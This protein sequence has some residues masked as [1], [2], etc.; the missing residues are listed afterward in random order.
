MSD[1]KTYLAKVAQGATLTQHETTDAFDLMMSGKTSPAQIGGFLMALRVRG[2]TVDEITGAAQTMRNKA[3]KVP[4]PENAIDTCGT[5]GD[6]KGTYNISTAAA[7]VVA[8]A[9]IPVAKHGNRSFTS[10]SGSADVLEALGVNLDVPPEKVSQCISEA[11]IGFMFAPSHHSAMR[12]VGPTRAE[13]GTRTLFNLL[14]PLSNPASTKYQVI[15]VFD[16]KWAEPLAHVLKNLGSKAVWVVHGADGMDE[17]TTTDISHITA[18]QENGNITS[19]DIT[20]EEVGLPRAQ[21]E[22]LLG[23]DAKVNASAIQ[24]LLE[25]TPGP[26]QDIVCLNAAA[27]LC[28]VKNSKDL[29]NGIQIAQDSIKSGRALQCLRKLI[30]LTTA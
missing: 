21:P 29:H 28:V 26:L 14:G 15:G 17:L 18:L 16:K 25:G 12:H 13:L 20:P 5:G 11:G 30:S 9:G 24:S 3:T 8:G 19:F 1:F 23:G 10:K 27:T 6:A 4:A 7:F 22:D 2:E